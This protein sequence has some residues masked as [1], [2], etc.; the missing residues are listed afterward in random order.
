[1]EITRGINNG[2]AVLTLSGRL[3]VADTPGRL[4]AA[5][6]QALSDGARAI[7][8]DLADVPYVDST[9]LGELIATHIAVSRQ[10]GRLALVCP[11]DR[12]TALFKLAGL[13]GVFVTYASLAD[14]R[15]A[16]AG[17]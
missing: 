17:A 16:L 5:A 6:T 3:T 10:Q 9:R 4:K 8:L 12:I 7:I 14:A 1:M 2:V 15:Y 13:E 11:T